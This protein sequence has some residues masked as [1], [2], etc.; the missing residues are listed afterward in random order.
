[1]REKLFMAVDLGTSF[2][3][4]GV[5]SLDGV[6]LTSCSAP[7]RDERPAPGVFIQKGDY[8]FEAVCSCI[9]TTTQQLGDRAR[10]IR[11]IAFTGQMAGSMG[12]DENWQDITT[13]S[14]SLDTRYVPY[15]D[16]QRRRLSEEL[17][18]IGG[19]NAPVMC[20]KYSWFQDQFP[21][22]HRRIAKYVM[23]NGYI[24]GRLSHIPVEEAAIDYSLITWTG[25]A[26]IRARQWSD[27]L[28]QK[29]GVDQTVLPKIVNC[30]AIGGYLAEDMAKILHLPSGIPLIVG[31]GDKVS[32]CVGA[33]VFE[34]GEMIFEAASY[35][36]ISC[37]VSQVRLDAQRRNYDVIGAID[38]GSYYAHKYIQGSGIS[39]DWFVDTFLRQPDESRAA[40]FTRAE[41]LARP[42]PPGSANMLCLGL[43]SGSAIPFDSELRG[44]FLGHTWSHHKG[45]FYRALLEGFSYDLALTLQSI[46]T[47]YPQYRTNRIKLIGGG[48]KSTI[49]P[50]ILADVTGCTFATLNRSD[51]ALWGAALLAAAGEGSVTDL[52]ALAKDHVGIGTEYVPD[53]VRTQQYA[54][55]IALY[56]TCA[57]TLH[58]LY[59]QL[60]R[61]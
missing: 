15:A 45:H 7:V 41:E 33:G 19:T 2:I 8:L 23:L 57:A 27:T 47:Q 12:V 14:C 34:E 40:A 35:G 59:R 29:L 56:E 5:Y 37:K 6:C 44:A 46:R 42:V 60:N 30:T 32:G 3:K 54:P 16:A 49:W 17:F 26:D 53:K 25:M 52:Q 61:L 51:V 9:Q 13:W 55:Y 18:E 24:I 38:N 50:Q 1:M 43:L 20:A 31:A 10:N 39:I 21:E 22:E 28:C 4:S 48:A 11:A 36:A 58:D